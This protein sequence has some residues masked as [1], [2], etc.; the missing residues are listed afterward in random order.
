MSQQQEVLAGMSGLLSSN[1]PVVIPPLIQFSG[2][3]NP[4]PYETTKAQLGSGGSSTDPIIFD[5]SGPR[6]GKPG[7]TLVAVPPPP[8]LPPPRT[9]PTIPVPITTW[10]IR[11]L[12]RQ[13]IAH[14]P[15]R[16]RS[17]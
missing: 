2:L 16:Q 3:I 15:P 12:E 14:A 10:P 8:G 5:L 7:E 9:S 13:P 11:V 17:A 4:I 6:G 1:N